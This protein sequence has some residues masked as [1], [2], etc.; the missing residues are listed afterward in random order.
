MSTAPVVEGMCYQSR[1]TAYRQMIVPTCHPKDCS[2]L[3]F[4]FS[5][6]QCRNAESLYNMSGDFCSVHALSKKGLTVVAHSI[7]VLRICT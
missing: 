1:K 3:Q 6:R 5:D 7:G 4:F 2:E